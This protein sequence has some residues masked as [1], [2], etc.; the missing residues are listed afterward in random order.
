[1]SHPSMAAF[2]FSPRKLETPIERGK[3]KNS[4]LRV[5]TA[6]SNEHTRAEAAF[7][8]IRVEQVGDAIAVQVCDGDAVRRG[9]GRGADGSRCKGAIPFA[10]KDVHRSILK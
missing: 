6:V 10:K 8:R 9:S 5:A 4:P 1:M 3:Q 7:F 2:M